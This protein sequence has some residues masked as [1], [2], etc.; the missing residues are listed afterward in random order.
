MSIFRSLNLQV[1]RRDV[2]KE[3]THSD[4]LEADGVIRQVLYKLG[5]HRV[6]FDIPAAFK[7]ITVIWDWNAHE[8]PPKDL[9]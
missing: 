3:P 2:W 1:L 9:L 7:E 5:I 6:S 8:I 4:V